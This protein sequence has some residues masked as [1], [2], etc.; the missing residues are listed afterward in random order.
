M[1]DLLSIFQQFALAQC[2]N[3]NGLPIT[4][5]Y[6]V[7]GSFRASI[8]LCININTDAGFQFN[9]DVVVCLT[10]SLQIYLTTI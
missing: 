6:P 9:S 2:Q 3:E 8:G 1:E 4:G 10:Q 7:V 5:N